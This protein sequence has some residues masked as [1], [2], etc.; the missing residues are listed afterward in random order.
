MEPVGHLG[1]INKV[2][3]GRAIITKY[4]FM[5]LTKE[6]VLGIVQLCS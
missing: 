3:W 2:A 1:G 6:S 4:L 5:L